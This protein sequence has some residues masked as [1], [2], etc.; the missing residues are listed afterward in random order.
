ME[1]TDVGGGFIRPSACKTRGAIK[2]HLS[3]QAMELP[4]AVCGGMGF[5]KPY[6]HCSSPNRIKPEWMTDT[7]GSSGM[8]FEGGV[9]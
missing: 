4:V 1:G 5:M 8:N 3:G 2:R 6:D 7:E 9:G